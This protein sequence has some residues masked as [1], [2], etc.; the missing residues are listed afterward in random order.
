[1]RYLGCARGVVHTHLPNELL[2]IVMQYLPGERALRGEAITNCL[3]GTYLFEKGSIR[4]IDRNEMIRIELENYEI[5]RKY[6][7]T[8]NFQYFR[9]AHIR[10]LVHAPMFGLVCIQSV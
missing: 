8:R 3:V 1:M 9:I 10:T 5:S 4:V 6:S 2:D 7:I